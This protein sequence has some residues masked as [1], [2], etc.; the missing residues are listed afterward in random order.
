MKRVIDEL[1]KEEAACEDQPR[2]FPLA[3]TVFARHPE[4]DLRVSREA[5]IAL[6][7]SA[8][9]RSPKAK[10]ST[11]QA[12]MTDGSSPIDHYRAALEILFTDLRLPTR[13]DRTAAK[14]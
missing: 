9:A 14:L 11:L 8:I 1:G 4:I 10:H 5:R 7:A 2:R 12:L 13:C 3:D 6:V